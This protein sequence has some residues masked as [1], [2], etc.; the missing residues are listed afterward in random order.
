MFRVVV[1]ASFTAEPIAPVLAFW[2]AQLGANFD[3]QFAPFQQVMQTLLDAAGLFATNA[4]GVNVVMVRDRRDAELDAAIRVAE[5]RDRTPLIVMVCDEHNRARLYPVAEKYDAAADRLG[6]IPYTQQ[7]FAALGTVLARQIMGLSLPP[8]KVIAVDCDN[9]LWDGICGED[10]PTGVRIGAD[11]RTLQ[12]FL[13]EQ[14]AAGML[15]CLAS[16]N[17]AADVLETFSRHPEM[18]LRLEHF[19]AMRLDWEPKPGNLVSLAAE[20]QL[21]L[22]SFIFVDDSSKEC[23][24][25][26]EERPEVLTLKLPTDAGRIPHFLKHVWAFDH[27]TVTH[28]DERRAASYTQLR[29]FGGAFRSAH[30]LEEFMAS[31][32]LRVDI[33]PVQKHETG[34]VAQLTQRTN[35]FN[36]TTIRRT[37]AEIRSLQNSHVC[38]S[39]HVADRFGAYGLTGVVIYG[40]SGGHLIVETFLLSCRVLGRGVEHRVMAHLGSMAETKVEVSFADSGRN[41][42]ARQFLQS[43]GSS[44]CFDAKF[45]RELRWKPA[46]AV[47]RTEQVIEAVPQ[48]RFLPFARIANELSTVEEILAAMATNETRMDEALSDAE[49]ALAGIWAELLQVPSVGPDDRFFD[50]GGHSLLAVLL[51]SKVRYR[52]GVE[53]PINDVYS[54]DMTLRDLAMKIEAMQGGDMDSREYEAIL[55]EVNALSDEEVKALLR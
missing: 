10:G 24:E 7:Y 2:G 1:S 34:R 23:E 5:A 20:L 52:F 41:Q 45:L 46:T 49:R 12:E 50:L 31:L 32:D 4:H 47:V 51:I 26:R 18:V 13:L 22:D 36:F 11:R 6:G 44:L 29:E 27:L 25:M 28:E 17:N 37:E 3:I 55:A 35:Q 40:S 30:T 48:H 19:T 38:L 54:A 43:I 14:R 16:K 8:Y 21:G 42:P 39:I 9:T 15:L 33:A 53:L